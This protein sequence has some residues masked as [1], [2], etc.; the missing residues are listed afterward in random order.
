MTQQR[1]I[2]VLKENL[3]KILERFLR[4]PPKPLRR[5]RLALAPAAAS[6]APA[7]GILAL[8]TPNS[9]D[10]L[11]MPTEI[12][13]L[14]LVASS[15]IA[16]SAPVRARV[17]QRNDAGV[18]ASVMRAVS[19]EN[20]SP[21]SAAASVAPSV[22]AS[23]APSVA[24]AAESA[25]AAETGAKSKS[26]SPEGSPRHLL[27][28]R[29]P[30][31]VEAVIQAER[32]LADNWRSAR[33]EKTLERLLADAL[34]GRDKALLTLSK[35]LMD[36]EDGAAVNKT[37]A[38]RLCCLA[39]LRGNAHAQFCCGQL[40][41]RGESPV[42]Q[43][44]SEA[45]KWYLPAAEQ[46]HLGAMVAAGR[47]L[48]ADGPSAEGEALLRRA[49]A[50]KDRRGRLLLGVICAEGKSVGLKQA[51]AEKWWRDF[52]RRKFAAL[53]PADDSADEVLID[54]STEPSQAA[55][56]KEPR[57]RPEKEK[58][59]SARKALRAAAKLFK[60][61]SAEPEEEPEGESDGEPMKVRER[62]Y[63]L[64]AARGAIEGLNV[65]NRFKHIH[66]GLEEALGEDFDDRVRDSEKGREQYDLRF[67][68]G[69]NP[70]LTPSQRRELKAKMGII[71]DAAPRLKRLLQERNW[72][73]EL[74]AVTSWEADYLK[75]NARIRLRS[76]Q[77]AVE[78]FVEEGE[79]LAKEDRAVNAPHRRAV[80]ELLAP[81]LEPDASKRAK[82][83]EKAGSPADRLLKI[84]TA[85][86]EEVEAVQ[87]EEAEAPAEATA[88]AA[89]TVTETPKTLDEKLTALA[90]TIERDEAT[91][92]AATGLERRPESLE[93]DEQL[94]A[95]A[96]LIW[97]DAKLLLAEQAAARL[98]E[99]KEKTT[100]GSRVEGERLLRL[101]VADGC[102]ESKYQLGLICYWGDGAP[103]NQADAVG[104]MRSAAADGH[105]A[106]SFYLCLWLEDRE[107][108][109]IWRRRLRYMAE[110]GH[111]FAQMALAE[112][113]IE[114]GNWREGFLF[115]SV[116]EAAGAEGAV[117]AGG[118][119]DLR[120]RCV[121]NIPDDRMAGL[122]RSAER[123]RKRV[124]DN[125]KKWRAVY[126]ELWG[127]EGK[128]FDV[129][130]R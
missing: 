13:A 20:A 109:V 105:V 5:I 61:D 1:P 60:S 85:L 70:P 30:D 47:I 67:D 56:R 71:K 37:L 58:N 93:A 125:V 55:L 15:A 83:A 11:F 46:G 18:F 79:Q 98:N 96:A 52:A 19:N 111:V 90:E 38:V 42:L 117:A 94:E 72:Q 116:A 23:V 7:A 82:L 127:I 107:D 108:E 14:A 113:L 122:E 81:E 89:P 110:Q 123:L 17:R 3:M 62:V 69:T 115:A 112:K 41:E 50:N 102:A 80:K 54:V 4:S 87:V 43:D 73:E 68:S 86:K 26:V 8:Q 9:P 104:W 31:L 76:I 99:V 130:W 92:R 33:G 65:A 45:L 32:A 74:D 28:E 118:A 44:R 129:W 126:A 103:E 53:P 106:A 75:K 16:L 40:R 48:C 120:K 100:D 97:R 51:D 6:A 34:R 84:A 29:L 128:G 27:E 10:F 59:A 121:K 64:G 114:E 36:G 124:R 35:K 21:S 57:I 63:R 49:V 91:L 78:A 95:V 119:V 22:A 77:G 101:N 12:T 39:A 25:S 66:L 88:D 2:K 24:P